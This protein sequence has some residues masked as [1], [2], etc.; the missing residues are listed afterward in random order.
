MGIKGNTSIDAPLAPSTMIL[1]SIPRRAITELISHR[2]KNYFR[3]AKFEA[4]LN[5]DSVTH[6]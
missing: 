5:G 3:T 4:E 2:G 6:F 1:P